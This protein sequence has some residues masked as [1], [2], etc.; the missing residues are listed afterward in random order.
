VQQKPGTR[1]C[2]GWHAGAERHAGSPQPWHKMKTLQ[3]VA[4]LSA[5]Q[6]S[7]QQGAGAQPCTQSHS[8]DQLM[9]SSLPPSKNGSQELVNLERADTT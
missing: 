2:G 1:G 5:Y 4:V 3:K 6:A 8:T 7:N 9:G